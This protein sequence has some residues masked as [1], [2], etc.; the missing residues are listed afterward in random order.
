M[1]SVEALPAFAHAPQGAAAP[2][3]VRSLNV[4]ACLAEGSL[5]RRAGVGLVNQADLALLMRN[6]T[7]GPADG[8]SF[9]RTRRRS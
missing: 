6:P 7:F 8:G 5:Q 1:G 2:G 4:A 9:A 3:A